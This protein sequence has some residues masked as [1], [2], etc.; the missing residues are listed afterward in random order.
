MATCPV[1]FNSPLNSPAVG[2][3]PPKSAGR[4]NRS[5]ILEIL[6]PVYV[7]GYQVKWGTVRVGISLENVDQ[8]IAALT[9]HLIV[10]GLL[11]AMLSLFAARSAA[12][13]ITRP[14]DR[15]VVAT[16]AIAK[17]DYSQLV[18]LQT[19]D[20]LE[21][22]S[23]HFDR[24]AG[25]VRRQQV[26]ILDSREHLARMNQSLEV[27]VEARTHALVESEAKYRVL[28]ESSPQGI[29]ILQSGHTVFANSALER[30]TGR[31]LSEVFAR[32]F[33]PVSVFAQG[34]WS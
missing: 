13:S 11:A 7:D 15:L 19:G 14:I 25:E 24:M 21:T 9:R 10:A 6:L 16:R 34:H 31:A 22:L 5:R 2:R 32:D 33:D 29:L 4:P 30:M 17:G 20:E 3:R 8:E 26:E 27:A 12:R 18:G 23:W 1:R 28:V